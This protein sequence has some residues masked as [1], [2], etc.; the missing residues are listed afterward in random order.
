MADTIL[1]A[2]DV[3]NTEIAAK[4][5]AA[6]ARLLGIDGGNLHL[7]GVIPDPHASY[8]GP[9][10]PDDMKAQVEA[11]TRS[12]L[13]GLAAAVAMDDASPKLHVRHGTI[14]TEILDLAGELDADLIVIGSHRPELIDYLLGPNAAR[15]VRHA[16]C[17]VFV[18][19]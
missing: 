18:V 3:Q 4:V 9:Y 13:E 7:V 19:R 8:V 14:H 10:I 5:V 6:A 12:G 1:A 16:D 17:S 11:A 2:V 15:V